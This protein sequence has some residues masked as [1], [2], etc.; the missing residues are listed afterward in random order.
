MSTI[1]KQIAAVEFQANS[2]QANAAL[3]SIRSDA[4]KARKTV[5]E[6]QEA[7]DKGITTMKGADGIEFDVAKRLRDATKEAKAFEQA[8]QSLM[9][10]VK[11]FDELWKNARMGTIENLTGQQI[12]AGMNA[13]KVQMERLK[14]G[15]KDDREKA[16]AIQS[17]LDESQKVLNKM[18]LDTDQIIHTFESG[19]KVA[20]EVLQREQKSLREMLRLTEQGSE[21]WQTYNR[22]L[23][24]IEKKV[25]ELGVAE[26]QLKGEIVTREDAMRVA[27]QQDKEATDRAI[28]SAQDRAA[29]AREVIDS[30]RQEVESIK[31]AMSAAQKDI[32]DTRE[33]IK[34][35]QQEADAINETASKRKEEANTRAAEARKAKEAAKETAKVEKEAYNS[36]KAEV[37][38]LD[39][40]IAGLQEKMK[41]QP[42]GNATA[43]KTEAADLRVTADKENEALA[44]AKEGTKS[45]RK[46]IKELDDDLKKLKATQKDTGALQAEE[47][48]TNKLK[49]DLD[50]LAITIDAL[51]KKREELTAAQKKGAEAAKQ[52]G[53]AVTMSAKE[54]AE[55]LAAMN[56]DASFKINT[57]GEVKVTNREQAQST[58]MSLIKN[59]GKDGRTPT[60]N[61][62]GGFMIQTRK[63]FDEVVKAF[64][65]KYNPEGEKKDTLAMIR[66]LVTEQGG[67]IKDGWMEGYTLQFTPDNEVRNELIK[68][69]QE[70]LAISKGQTQATQENTQA[71]KANAEAEK[72][73]AKIASQITE[74]EKQRAQLEKQLAEAKQ[75]SNKTSEEQKRIEDEIA[76]KTAELTQKRADLATKENEVTEAKRK[77][78]EAEKA[79]AEAEAKATQGSDERKKTEQ[80]LANLQQQR[81][82]K[83]KALA[84]QEQKMSDAQTRERE[85]TDAVTDAVNAQK[86]TLKDN[87]EARQRNRQEIEHLQ[88]QEEQHI[89]TLQRE[90][91]AMVEATEEINRQA[92]AEATANSEVSQLQTNSIEKIQQAIKVL[93]AENSTIDANSEEWQENERTIGSL[94]QQLDDLKQQSAELRGETMSL[95]Q[96]EEI[97]SRAGTD[98]F[99]AT[100]KQMQQAT[101]A[102]ERQR[103]ALIKT[104]QQKQRDGV[105]TKEEE[106]ELQRLEK[107]LRDLK[108]E[109]DNFNMSH[110]RM[111]E[112]LKAP[113]SAKDLEELKAAIKRADGELKHMEHSLGTNNKK[114]QDFAAQ[115]KNAKNEL[116]QM[117]GQSKA[118]STAFEKAW[119]R[120]QTY[121]T[122]YV[123]AA[124]ILQ[125]VMSTMG[126]VMVLSDR[127]GEVRKTTGMTADEVGRLSDNLAKMDVRTSLTEL[128]SISAS[129]GQLGLKSMEDIQGFTEAAN[130]LMVALP[131]M[132]KEAATEMMRVAIATGEVDKIRKQLQDG[133]VEGSSATA[134]A[135]EKIASTIDRLRASSA[136]TA[137]EITDFIKRVGAVGAQSGISI[138]QVAA[139]GSTVSSLG[140]RVEMSATALSRMI[141]AIRNNAFDV[142]KA[143]GVTPNSLRE[144][145]DTGRAMEAILMIFQH[146]KDQNMDAD[147]VEKMLGMGG[148]Q[149]VMKELNQM[150][151]RA[152]IVFSGLSQNV[153]ELRHQLGVSAQAYEENIAIQQEFD[154]MNDTTAA[155]WERLKNQ[156]EETIVSDSTQSFLGGVIDFLRAIVNFITGN[157]H[158][159][160]RG[161]SDLLK[162]FLVY[163]SVLKIGLGEAIFV[164]SIEGLKN[165]SLGLTNIIGYTQKYI[166][167]S[168]MLSGAQMELSAATDAVAAAEA[169]QKVAAIEACMAQEGLNKSML[170]NLW[171]AAAAAV[172]ALGVAIYGWIDSMKE[173]GREA[174]RYQAELDREQQQVNKLTDSIGKARVKMEEAD[175]EVEA[176]KKALEGAREATDGTTKSAEQLAQAEANL[177]EKEEK[178]KQ[179]MAEHK[180]LI[181]LFNSQYSQ[182]LGFMLSEVSSNLELAR[183][184]DLVNAKLRESLTLKQQ[185]AA[186]ERVE[187]EMGGDRDD[188]YATLYDT[189]GRFV[190]DDPTK[191]ASVMAGITKA[192]NSAKDEVD[193]RVQINK[194]FKDN[195]LR[196]LIG[197]AASANA[198]AYFNKV[199]DIRK[200]KDQQAEQFQGQ[201]TADREMTQSELVRVGKVSTQNFY[202]LQKKYRKST[203]KD[204]AQ[205]AANLLMQMDQI[206]NL[207]SNVSKSYDL[208]DEKQEADY[209][210]YW[211]AWMK[212]SSYKNNRAALLKEAGDLYKPQSGNNKSGGKGGGGGGGT[213]PWGTNQPAESTDWKNMSAEALV[214]R[215][216]QMNQFVNA[217]QTDSDVTAVLA[218][219]KALKAAIEKGMSKDM[220]TVIEWYNTERLKIQDEL[221]A[222]H[223]TNTGAWQ[224]PKKQRAAHKQFKL[225][226][227]A[228]LE[229]LDAYYTE[230]KTNIEKARNNEEITEG[231]AWRR[232]LKNENEWH[233]RRAEL[234]KLYS[235]KAGEVSAAEQDAI[236]KIIAERT[237]DSETFVKAMI[238][239]TIGFAKMIEASGEKGAAMVHDWYAKIGL[240]YERDFLK[241]Q[242][243]I[244]KQVKFIEDTLAKE[245]PY[246][247]IAKNLQDNLD[248]MG[249]LAAKYR[250]ENDE[251]ER[252]GKEKRYS[253]QDITAQSYKE[254]AFYLQ[255]A[256]DAYSID[257]NE[258]LRRMAQEGMAAT[259]EEISKS[260]LLKQAV[261]GQLRK[262]Y[263]EVQ[264]AVKKEAAQIKKDV[265]IMWNDDTLGPNG[266]SIKATFDKSIARMGVQ[267]DS[268]SRANSLIG[269]GYAS[270]SVATRLAMKQ[271]EMQMR[272]QKAQFDTFRYQ[273]HQ[274]E[275]TLRAQAREY[276]RISEQMKQQKR[277]A[278]AEEQHMKAV[279]ALRDADNVRRSLG[280]T[281]AEE[282]KKEEQQ[283]AELLKLQEESQ[284]KLYQSLREW[285]TLLASSMQSVF[286]ASHTADPE[287]YNELAKLNLTGKGGPG[288]GTYII[289]DNS[290]TEDATA[291]YEYLDEREAL[292]RQREIENDNAV[293]EAWEKVWD[294]INQ[295]INDTITDQLNAMMQNAAVDA[296]TDALGA[297]TG[298]LEGLTGAINGLSGAIYTSQA[299]QDTKVLGTG[300][301]GLDENGVPNALK[302]P[303]EGVAETPS[304]TPVWQ[305][306]TGEGEAGQQG[307]HVPLALPEENPFA[308]YAEW[309]SYATDT[310]L[311]NQQ[312]VKRG[313]QQ[314]TQQMG[315]N[316]KNMF[317]AMVSA[318]NLYGAAYQAMSN[319]NLDATQKAQM[320]ILQG[321]GSMAMAGLDV[322]KSQMTADAASKAP[323]VLGKLWSQLGW[324][325]APV[326]AGFTALLGG[327]MGLATSKISKSKST[328]SQVTGASVSAGR[329]ATGMLTYAEGNVNEFTD[330]STLTVGR[331]YNVD[332][333]DG[334]TY[335]AKY[336]GTNPRTHITSGPEF[337]LAGEA[338]REAIIDAHT[339]RLMQMDDTGIWRAIQTLYNGGSI[340]AVR[341]RRGRGVPAFADGNLDDFADYTEAAEYSGYS[342][343]SDLMSLQASIDRQSDLL[344]DLRVNGIKAT[345]DVYGKG[346]L[347]DSYDRGK[348][349]VQRHGVNY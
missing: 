345:F 118:T 72:E 267:Q 280:L 28:K 23:E 109:Q 172:I 281:L 76:K 203:A 232:N 90:Q 283:M 163:W 155:K 128:M 173:G 177:L 337:H 74:L 117:E 336:T 347:V 2:R 184:R 33:A 208:S 176:A 43:G 35:K 206:D 301:M 37:E 183:A 245:R 323:G 142:A 149:E 349:E 265:E 146:I 145:F 113:K 40:K 169:R 65:S 157:V 276:E 182:Y 87:K 304:W 222:R 216:K 159:V 52:D 151:A 64:H 194:I 135:M 332:G 299:S 287:Y 212:W 94:T 132:G 22:Q 240:G 63:Q 115:V 197:T 84:E 188:K 49:G 81:T 205:N 320:I 201:R 73:A 14:L 175:K 249:V 271:I 306:Q 150:G 329:L 24:T 168:K 241:S 217:I 70:L 298:A 66:N 123:S 310:I 270:D 160:L 170:A 26:R 302:I 213:N 126:D 254:M 108:F 50:T 89:N 291:H 215:R 134:V 339:T 25:K 348:K 180:R 335:R 147:S 4:D 167:Y 239:K 138:D 255:Q 136:S 12:K 263:Q 105:A 161:L 101:Q 174:A 250:R 343:G 242:Q 181:E 6:M 273:A 32:D 223:L 225:E 333:A 59:V 186:L 53:E 164:K 303:E 143:I 67:L 226:M 1:T 284:A 104:I 318:C 98:G 210:K 60:I 247:G 152:G 20:E 200:A 127:M 7:L 19:G 325:A 324:W 274:R 122:F 221:H 107:V 191:K 330:P 334:K 295:K 71:A 237:G 56:K 256:G 233:Q 38:E 207:R 54:A 148:M 192:A 133:T 85:A 313:D 297:N 154:R 305:Q 162:V 198:I 346:G 187:K 166:M 227:D 93:E 158:P 344:E 42:G 17:V 300:D 124:A 111:D 131:E 110:K 243:A 30:K 235:D 41:G 322:Q 190:R 165:L 285:S 307:W 139:L 293:A 10:G 51:K 27:N 331:S 244:T 246:D 326:F 116:K 199:F 292:E 248:K 294:D 277:Y 264:D 18:K 114:Y 279:G 315:E 321:V 15:D 236:V 220:R 141:P 78:T 341:R 153:D 229:E 16:R 9:R 55:A 328:I 251:L 268:V 308:K 340:S 79:A 95:A 289:I 3:E 238:Q 261:M 189:V 11:A 83:A 121:V 86:Q 316:S 119:D 102:I 275:N 31:E 311:N 314:T 260:D 290:G 252:Q 266:Q 171:M 262:T 179:A 272:M 77:A 327:L 257:I 137:P 29:A 219:D 288:A 112:L 130:K 99:F 88:A 218:E 92:N 5:Q 100:A 44:K 259:A 338:G 68:R 214:A 228:Y 211:G 129:A 46:E 309:S 75:Q 204:R 278:E 57:K 106:A 97:A 319:E 317:A 58:L 103:D 34:L 185:E 39:K 234:Q 193:F 80:K 286:E 91:E 82:E 62:D 61:S 224:D 258:L 342:D 69:R 231:E 96:A 13:A 253:D 195:G 178:K 21:E 156:I 282:A 230:R 296:N 269:A 144:L 45:L 202:A 140:M 8:A 125:K 196:N 47:D 120:F 312:K 209:K 48:A 36:V